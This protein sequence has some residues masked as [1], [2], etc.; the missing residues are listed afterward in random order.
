MED[1]EVKLTG[2]LKWMK[3]DALIALMPHLEPMLRKK[4]GG[5]RQRS[6]VSK[7]ADK[8]SRSTKL[9]QDKDSRKVTTNSAWFIDKN[10]TE[11]ML[12]KKLREIIGSRGRKGTNVKETIRSLEALAKAA[13]LHGPRKEIPVLMYLIA[14]LF[15]SHKAIDEYMELH[16]WR[17][18]HR[19]M[20][21]ILTILESNKTIVLGVMDEEDITDI[22]V[23]SQ[24]KK[25]VASDADVG[26]DGL[27]AGGPLLSDSNAT[28][29]IKIVG[30]LE[31]FLMRLDDEHTKSLQQINPHT[32]VSILACDNL[33][34]LLSYSML[35]SIRRTRNACH[36]EFLVYLI[37]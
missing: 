7:K 14:S 11:E 10:V 4:K 15:D 25:S 33:P 19:Y 37:K 13:R 28:G 36:D 24:A 5:D 26:L 31:T 21:R 18:G 35:S 9:E 8:S 30:S 17:T 22:V 16:D 20:T 27:E 1:G 34:L 6:Q 3:I 29:P 2:R 12:D 23:G 32:Q